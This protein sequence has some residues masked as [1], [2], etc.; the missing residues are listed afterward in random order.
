MHFEHSTSFHRYFTVVIAGI[1]G[2]NL[3]DCVSVVAYLR[4]RAFAAQKA[5]EMKQ[6]AQERQSSEDR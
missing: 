1:V 3:P 5:K 4:I 6:E 2:M